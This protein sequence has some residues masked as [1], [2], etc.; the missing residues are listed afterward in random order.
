V[1]TLA[2]TKISAEPVVSKQNLKELRV[3]V[4]A[5]T[6]P[7]WE[8]DA[9]PRFVFDLTKHL[10]QKV[11][12]WVLV[13]H[14]PGAKMEEEIDGVR[15]LR[16][17]YFFPKRMQTLCYEGGILPNLKSKWLARL[18]LP[19]FL[20]AQGFYIWRTVRK[21][22]I[23]FIHC[24][25]IIP[26]GF[27]V[28]LIHSIYKIPYMVTALGA[29]VYAFKKNAFIK[30]IKRF[31]LNRA[32]CCTVNSVS[33]QRSLESIAQKTRLSYNPNGVDEELFCENKEDV[34]LK[35]ELGIQGIFL[36]SVGRFAEKKGFK[37]LIAAMPK[38][39]EKQPL[40]KL[41]LAGFGPEEEALK[42][43][44]KILQLSDSIIFPGKK[45]GRELAT[46]FATADIFIGPSIIVGG[47]D[48]EGQGVVFVEAMSSGTTVVASNVGGIPDM[49][50]DGVTGL[51]VPEK[52]SDCI[53]EKVITLC[54]NPELRKTLAENARQLV[55][56]KYCWK[57]IASGFLDI[58]K[59]TLRHVTHEE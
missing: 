34:K 23:N 57:K 27:F 38:I 1:L 30:L 7:R 56:E 14:A 46:Y 17:P 31:T 15:I 43:Q 5:T 18:Q 45:S 25:W 49:I 36:F 16:F 13:P 24:H 32:H 39:L 10:A 37:Y 20:A 40:A 53:A 6:F 41:V 2:Q 59:N 3:L 28:A 21:Y 8:D 9:E 58:Y 51:L 29:D 48:T 44:V 19:F 26:Q 52:D 55:L 4:L 54:E 47:G 11:S 22:K 33:V 42:Q 50:K 12:L 35:D